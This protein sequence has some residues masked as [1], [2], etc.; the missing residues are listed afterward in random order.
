MNKETVRITLHDDLGMRKC[1]RNLF[2]KFSQAI[3]KNSIWRFVE[4]LEQIEQRERDLKLLR[5]INPGFFSATRRL[6][7][8]DRSGLQKEKYD[9]RKEYLNQNDAVFFHKVLGATQ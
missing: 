6:N 9:H 3:K 7:E 5:E 8:W 1:V 4:I 2:S